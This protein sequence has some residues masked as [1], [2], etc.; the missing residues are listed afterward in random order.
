MLEDAAARYQY[1]VPYWFKVQPWGNRQTHA[2]I[3]VTVLNVRHL[4]A[5]PPGSKFCRYTVYTAHVIG[6]GLYQHFHKMCH[7]TFTSHVNWLS[8]QEVKG[9]VEMFDFRHL[10]TWHPWIFS[11]RSQDTFLLSVWRTKQV[12]MLRQNAVFSNPGQVFLCFFFLSNPLWQ[13]KKITFFLVATHF[14]R[15]APPT[16]PE[17]EQGVWGG[18]GG[19][20]KIYCFASLLFSI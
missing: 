2:L 7:I 1:F 15:P 4:S 8:Y 11:R 18:R 12:A 13:E 6:C 19:T 20:L 10:E 9:M 16:L 14:G 17:T 3:I 5:Q